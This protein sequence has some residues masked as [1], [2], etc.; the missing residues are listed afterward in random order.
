MSE[1]NVFDCTK[2]H[3]VQLFQFSYYCLGST[4]GGCWKYNPVYGGMLLGCVEE[5]SMSYVGAERGE[6]GVA[7]EFIGRGTF[8]RGAFS[9][10]EGLRG[11][12]SCG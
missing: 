5:F 3:F 7:V 9:I 6:I 10:V 8:D 4:C 2:I 1:T 12:K 11:S